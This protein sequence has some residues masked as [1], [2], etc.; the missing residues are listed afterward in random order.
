MTKRTALIT[1]GGGDIGGAI[2]SRFLDDGGRVVLVDRS[3][4]ALDAA[5]ELLQAGPGCLLGIVADVASEGATK[6]YVAEAL[7]FLDRVDAF[8]NNAGIEGAAAPITDYSFERFQQVL[9]VN[10]HGVFLGMKYVLPGMLARGRGA[11]VNTASISG[12][13]GADNLSGYVAS[14]HA[15]VGLTRTAAL[16]VAAYGVRVN[17]VCPS[18]VEGRMIQSIGAMTADLPSAAPQR[19]FAERN[20]MKRLATADEVAN[21]ALF[22]AS[23]AASFVNGA[24][25]V[26]DGARSVQ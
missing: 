15:V 16:E 21:V 17:A 4:E 13:R 7:G 9:A 5:I 18:G 6:G 8:F 12:L 14:K 11:V 1:G 19:G 22:L 23:D 25:W 26:V 2:A 24:A 10:V 3:R 20:P